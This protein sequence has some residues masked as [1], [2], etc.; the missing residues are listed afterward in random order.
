MNHPTSVGQVHADNAARSL[1]SEYRVVGRGKA[2][3]G[4]IDRKRGLPTWR[5]ELEDTHRSP[6]KRVGK[7]S[8]DTQRIPMAR[9]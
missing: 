5:K 2:A 1:A 8:E 3:R 6:R 7:Q 4:R 9:G